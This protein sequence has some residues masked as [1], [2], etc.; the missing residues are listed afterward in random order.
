MFLWVT[1]KEVEVLAA[2]L[3]SAMRHAHKGN[4]KGQAK[5]GDAWLAK[6][7]NDRLGTLRAVY[8]KIG[9]DPD[10]ITPTGESP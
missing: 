1:D 8:I 4:A 10:L 9:K 3:R 5:F 2:V 6:H 7:K